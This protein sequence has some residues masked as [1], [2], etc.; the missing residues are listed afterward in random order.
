MV[1]HHVQR[2]RENLHLFDNR[3]EEDPDSLVVEVVHLFLCCDD[4]MVVHCH[5]NHVVV[6][7][8]LAIHCKVNC[9]REGL[10]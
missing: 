6:V 9:F 2:S 5:E 1:L 3:K 8:F 4:A 10:L 7:D